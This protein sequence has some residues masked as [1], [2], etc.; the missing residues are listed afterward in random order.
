M[1]SS[2]VKVTA[3]KDFVDTWRPTATLRDSDLL[4]IL[5]LCIISGCRRDYSAS[6]SLIIVMIEELLPYEVPRR[7]NSGSDKLLDSV[8]LIHGIL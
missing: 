6:G 1:P 8:D 3:V 2:V 7:F 5:G 4:Q